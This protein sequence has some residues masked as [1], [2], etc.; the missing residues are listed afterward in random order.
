MKTDI[1]HRKDITD[2]MVKAIGQRLNAGQLCALPTETVYGL[3][4]S[5][6]D[7]AAIE[8]IYLAKGRP[9]DNPL[10]LHVANLAML[11]DIAAYVS[12]D[13]TRLMEAFWPGPLTL[14][15]KKHAHILNAVTAGL[16]TVA[17][18]MPNHPL[19]LKIIAAAQTPLAAPSANRSG[20]PSATTFQHVLDDLDGRID[21]IIDDGDCAIGIESTVLDV[22][23]DKM[24]I[25]RPGLISKADIEAHLKRPVDV[26]AGSPE[27]PKSPGIKYAHYQP[28]GH[29]T[30]LKGPLETMFETLQ[31]IDKTPGQIVLC[32]NEWADHFSFLPVRPIGSLSDIRDMGQQVYKALREMDDLEMTDIYILLHPAMGDAILDRL[33]KAANQTI[34]DLEGDR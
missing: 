14:V 12:D 16:D 1:F 17:V 18:R 3:A 22:S 25:L 29:V 7:Q 8:K 15:F 24:T 19:T 6:Y 20:R 27:T 32:P 31:G 23:T 2:T 13:A 4:A 30:L 21:M 9:A 28:N 11:K 34:L 10:I 26:Y 33:K 5:G